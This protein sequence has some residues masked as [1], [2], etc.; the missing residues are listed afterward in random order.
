MS[1]IHTVV[2]QTQTVGYDFKQNTASFSDKNIIKENDKIS[3][4]YFWKS[5][6]Y[7]GE[8]CFGRT[9]DLT[10]LIN[11]P[12]GYL[13]GKLSDT[14]DLDYYRFNISEYRILSVASDK[15]NLDITITLD[16][17]PESCNYDLILYDANGNQVGIGTDNGNGGKS[18][19][20]PNWNM[21]NRE[22]T[23]KVQAKDGSEINVQEYYHLSF[24][25]Q[26]AKD[27]VLSSEIKEMQEYG[28]ALRQKL[29]EGQD[30]AA[31]IQ[32]LSE[33]REKYADH[34]EQQMEELHKSQAKEFLPE[35][36]EFDESMLEELLVKMASGENLTEQEKGL[37]N[38]FAS[39]G[40]IDSAAALN[41][42]QTT[43]K[44]EIFARMKQ[45]G[46]NPLAYNFE[47]EIS[48]D[49][50]AS[51]TGIEDEEVKSKVETII[52]RCSEELVDI[53]ISSNNDIQK[54]SQKEQYILK[55][56]LEVEKF[57]KKATNGTTSLSDITVENGKIKGLSGT[58]DILLNHPGENQTYM[59]YQEDILSIKNFERLHG[60][61]LLEEFC[62]GYMISGGNILVN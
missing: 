22:Y 42:L 26:P 1:V 15:Y 7:T 38:I 4:D 39:A 12:D 6:K 27:N 19:T 33:I 45:A 56:A 23:I 14:K 36:T 51:V 48:L 21:E 53:Y 8:D 17:I 34:Y 13:Q 60:S 32:A 47:I 43:L 31:E 25:T 35:G 58:L 11:Q 49:G 44:E 28:L 59:D 46:I 24:Q 62:V 20:I 40:A 29:H 3:N 54:L 5:N 10:A 37:V 52:S 9:P 50:K 61:G 16:H 18:V 2:M 55:A 57:L 30:A 41:K